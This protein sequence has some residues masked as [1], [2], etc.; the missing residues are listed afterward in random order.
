MVDRKRGRW[1]QEFRRRHFLHQPCCMR[2]E[3][4]GRV[5]VGTQ[6]DHIVALANGGKDFDEDPDNAQTLCVPCHEIKTAEDLGYTQRTEGDVNGLPVDP[7]HHW[8]TEPCQ[9]PR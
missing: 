4:M 7:A 9:T 2:C 8:N 6:I 1:L 3:S 5:T